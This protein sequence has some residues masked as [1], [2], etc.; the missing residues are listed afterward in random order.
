[1][2]TRPEAAFQP[3][4][5]EMTQQW[6]GVIAKHE[7]EVARGGGARAC[8]HSVCSR[9]VEEKKNPHSDNYSQAKSIQEQIHAS[10]ERESRGTNPGNKSWC[11]DKRDTRLS[12]VGSHPCGQSE[13]STLK[14]RYVENH[15]IYFRNED[16]DI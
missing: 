9:N 14:S 5:E 15:T 2:E 1:M 4:A 11:W 12:S 13:V 8:D 16:R 10:K 6:C 7:M 3:R